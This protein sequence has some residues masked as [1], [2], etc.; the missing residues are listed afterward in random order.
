AVGLSFI[1]ELPD[2]GILIEAQAAKYQTRT[3]VDPH[4]LCE[5]VRIPLDLPPQTIQ[6]KKNADM[7]ERNLHDHLRLRVLYRTRSDGSLLVTVSMFNAKTR[8]GSTPPS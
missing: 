1:I 5:W 2:E 3:P 6:F 7:V 8:G 4:N